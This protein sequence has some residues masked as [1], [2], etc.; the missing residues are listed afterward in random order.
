MFKKILSALLLLAAILTPTDAQ[1]AR[2]LD[3]TR[4]QWAAQ[5]LDRFAGEAI[6][7]TGAPGMA[8]AIVYKDE[9]VYVRGFGVRKAGELG[10][11]DPDTVFQIGNLSEPLATTVLAAIMDNAYLTWDDRIQHL[12][13]DFRL[14]DEYVTNQITVRDLMGHRSGLPVNAGN[15]L[16]D[17]GYHQDDILARLRLLPLNGFRDFFEDVD[18]GVTEAALASALQYGDTWENLIQAELFQPLGMKSSSTE[19]ASHFNSLNRAALHVPVD[20]R[21]TPKYQFDTDAAAPATG[22][23]SSARD[24]AQW[25]M[26]LLN[27]GTLR[28]Q[29]LIEPSQLAE[30]YS[31]QTFV[32]FNSDSWPQFYGLGWNIE[33]TQTGKRH[34]WQTGDLSRGGSSSV[35]LYPDDQIGIVVLTNAA[36]TGLAQATVHYFFDILYKGFSPNGHP[37]RDWLDLE[38]ELVRQ[39][40]DADSA[41]ITDYAKLQRPSPAVPPTL[42]LPGYVGKYRS[43]YYGDLEIRMDQGGLTMS[44]GARGATYSL[45]HWNQDT[46]TYFFDG[47]SQ[48]PG[49]RGVVF[50]LN[51]NESVRFVRIDNFS[52]VEG[53]DTFGVIAS[54]AIAFTPNDPRS[55][56]LPGSKRPKRL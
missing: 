19:Y 26:L 17:L 46:F 50:A 40:A 39:R 15:L 4:V 11:V 30:I 9:V 6:Q 27:R 18:F 54:P 14:S 34:I 38:S 31:P 28:G 32:G 2:T 25:M 8:I 29:R 53:N 55:H 43:Q 51:G 44:I 42:A 24:L 33:F 7:K 48:P 45:K 13:P 12:D 10:P 36:P 1:P 23:G 21:M 5:W 56:R 41:R 49:T 47:A 20:G 37:S 22:V 52:A 16:Q 3:L 35:A